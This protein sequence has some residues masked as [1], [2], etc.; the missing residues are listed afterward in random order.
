MSIL[1]ELT[2]LGSSRHS[3]VQSLLNHRCYRLHVNTIVLAWSEQPLPEWISIVTTKL[4]HRLLKLLRVFAK[5]ILGILDLVSF[6][7]LIVN[8]DINDFIKLLWNG[9]C[10]VLLNL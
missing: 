10:I 2:E 8:N 6:L 9:H 3:S 5:L 7:P 4:S 1:E